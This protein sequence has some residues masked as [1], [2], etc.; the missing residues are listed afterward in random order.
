M[1]ATT[2]FTVATYDK[3]LSEYIE[4]GEPAAVYGRKQLLGKAIKKVEF[5]PEEE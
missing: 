2:T 1:T 3:E 5:S 4:E